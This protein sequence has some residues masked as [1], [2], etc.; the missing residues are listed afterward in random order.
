[1]GL[2][3]VRDYIIMKRAEIQ[4]IASLGPNGERRAY[5]FRF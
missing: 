2:R 5:E 4:S 1:M 3:R